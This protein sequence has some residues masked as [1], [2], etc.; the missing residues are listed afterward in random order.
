MSASGEG[1]ARPARI[2][3]VLICGGVWHDMDFAR[4][5]LLKL[6]AEDER[7]RTRVFENYETIEAIEALRTDMHATFATKV[8]LKDEIGKVRTDILEIRSDVRD[9]QAD[10]RAVRSEMGDMRTELKQHTTVLCESVRDDIRIV[11]EGVAN[12]AA[13]ADAPKRG[14]RKR[15]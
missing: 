2:D 6:L 8:E 11:A 7:V 14:P 15:K 13:K 9:L 3:C 5:E 4:L 12:L 1:E 10:M